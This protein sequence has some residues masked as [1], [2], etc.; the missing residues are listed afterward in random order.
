MAYN[1]RNPA[2]VDR[3]RFVLSAGHGSA[4]LYSLLF[5]PASISRPLLADCSEAFSARNGQ[6]PVDDLR[7]LALSCQM[8][9]SIAH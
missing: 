4:L 2:W 6:S 7:Y 3:G 5:E 9:V 1:P 8:L